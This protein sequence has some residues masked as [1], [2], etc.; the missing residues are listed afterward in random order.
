MEQFVFDFDATGQDDQ[1]AYRRRLFHVH[2]V[3]DRDPWLQVRDVN[4]RGAQI[5]AEP[6]QLGRALPRCP[7]RPTLQT[8]E[9]DE[10][11][12]CNDQGHKR[13]RD[14]PPDAMRGSGFRRWTFGVKHFVF[15][16]NRARADHEQEESGGR[17]S[18]KNYRPP[19]PIGVKG[20]CSPQNNRRKLSSL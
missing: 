12:R 7:R 2:A 8:Q 3:I 14:W 18:P 1:L 11:R 13:Q 17:L 10:N 19:R 15:R 4:E 6:F 16:R 20:G 9:D 5:F